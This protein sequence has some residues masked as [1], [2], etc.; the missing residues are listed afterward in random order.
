MPLYKYFRPGLAQPVLGDLTLRLSPPSALKDPYEA[1]ASLGTVMDPFI[2]TW[3]LQRDNAGGAFY[4]RR[5]G[6]RSHTRCA[7]TGRNAS[8]FG[9]FR[10]CLVP[11]R[12]A[13]LSRR[14]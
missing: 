14:P 7:G 9:R 1:R 10:V 8:Q 13:L 12:Q 2:F 5:C 4:Q 11:G 3:L 6:T